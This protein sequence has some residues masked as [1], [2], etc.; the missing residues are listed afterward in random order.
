MEQKLVQILLYEAQEHNLYLFLCLDLILKL[1]FAHFYIA[2]LKCKFPFYSQFSPNNN[3]LPKLS[4]IQN[5]EKFSSDSVNVPWPCTGARCLHPCSCSRRCVGAGGQ[6]RGRAWAGG[7]LARRSWASTR[8]SCRGEWGWARWR[9]GCRT[10]WCWS[11]P[12]GGLWERRGGRGCAS[13]TPAAATARACAPAAT[14]G[15]GR[16]TCGGRASADSWRPSAACAWD[17][18]VSKGAGSATAPARRQ[19]SPGWWATTSPAT[20]TATTCSASRASRR[21]GPLVASAAPPPWSRATTPAA[22]RSGRAWTTGSCGW[23]SSAT[24]PRRRSERANTTTL[25]YGNARTQDSSGKQH[26]MTD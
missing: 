26:L 21:S 3:S 19:A 25:S 15:C 16:P 24:T 8:T 5:F 9:Q 13:A 4:L 11:C 18:A 17:R 20:T 6:G 12:A 22:P 14:G 7:S 1:T 10:G 23:G 2:A